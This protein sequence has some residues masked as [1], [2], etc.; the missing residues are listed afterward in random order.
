MEIQEN[1]SLGNDTQ[2]VEDF[3]IGP[4]SGGIFHIYDIC[5]PERPKARKQY[6]HFGDNRGL[7]NPL[8]S[9][10]MTCVLMPSEVHQCPGPFYSGLRIG[11][12]AALIPTYPNVRVA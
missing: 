1:T 4:Q 6:I 12:F 10:Q 3:D 2:L 11:P 5:S 9:M 8:N 7:I